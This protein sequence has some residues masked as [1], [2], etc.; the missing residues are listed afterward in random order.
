MGKGGCRQPAG[1]SP[2]G[3]HDRRRAKGLFV[4][5]GFTA[6]IAELT[7]GESEALL[8]F[9][10]AH[11]AKPEFTI[12]WRWKLGDVT[13]GTIGSARTTRRST[14]FPRSASCTAA[15]LGDRPV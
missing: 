2:R 12:R 7:E 1:R 14:T 6:R 8:G 5:S 9:L 15:I 4:N 3:A 13:F 10:F 11:L